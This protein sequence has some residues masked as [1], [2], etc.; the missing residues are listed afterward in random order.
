MAIDLKSQLDLAAAIKSLDTGN[1]NWSYVIR[2]VTVDG[3]EFV[4][5]DSN[6]NAISDSRPADFP[7]DSDI[8]SRQADMHSKA[9]AGKTYEEMLASY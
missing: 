3:I 8:V 6:G 2:G 7:S 1:K 5:A 4:K 9:D